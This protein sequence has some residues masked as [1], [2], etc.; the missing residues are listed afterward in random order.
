[1]GY[2]WRGEGIGM[3]AMEAGTRGGWPELRRYQQEV[4]G[5]VLASALEGRGLTF[6]VMVSRQG[7]KN[8]LSARLEFA[9]LARHMNRAFDGV[10]CA[11]TFEP[12][13]RVSLRR[14]W[15]RIQAIGLGGLAHIE[16]GNAV[17]LGRA[18]QVFFSAAPGASVVGHT[19]HLL[20]EVDEA[21][22]V[23]A[24]KFD[25]DFRP[26]AASTNATTVYYGTA[27][28]ETDLLAEVRR[29]HLEMERRDGIRRHFEYDWEV[30]ARSHPAYGDFVAQ[31][32]AR[33][34]EDHP[35]FLTQYCLRPLPGGGRLFTAAQR[36]LLQGVHS[37][38]SAPQRAEERGRVLGYVAGL[39]VG[40]E[41]LRNADRGSRGRHG[42]GEATPNTSQQSV[43][44]RTAHS[45]ERAPRSAIRIPHSNDWTVL[46]IARVVAPSSGAL[47]QEPGIEV[48]EQAA[49]QG[50]S[51]AELVGGLARLVRDVWRV[52]RLVIDATGV[53]EGLASAL[54]ALR[55]GPARARPESERAA[56]RGR[57]GPLEVVRLRL[58]EE[59][60][61]ALGYGLLATVNSGRL[62]LYRQDGSAE[63]R[64]LWRELELARAEYRPNRRLAWHVDPRDGH[65]DYLMSLALT[66]E[67]AQGLEPRTARGRDEG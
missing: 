54:A 14:L 53:G 59:R 35:L 64:A 62:R 15:S 48:V 34:G 27:W 10:K 39:D 23:D 6:S 33:L 32:R 22:D 11:P 45:P 3:G 9:M 42:E 40:G 16:G 56:E 1:M 4:A 12:Q 49:W 46:T 21:Q 29:R 7:G 55:A 25:K 63:C 20:L 66:V 8:E 2:E 31:E 26:M 58:T 24:D 51:H 41:L 61:S 65:D 17:R 36:E 5:A 30:V 52:R 13:G 43:I 67:A 57:A 18:R 60:K 28:S 47:L 50:V 38:L 44:E 37:R 19:V